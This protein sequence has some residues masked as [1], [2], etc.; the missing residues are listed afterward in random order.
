VPA[1]SEPATPEP[2]ATRTTGSPAATAPTI[3]TRG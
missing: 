1:G 2:Q 3:R